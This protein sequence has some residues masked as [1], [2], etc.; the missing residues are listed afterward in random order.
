M[1]SNSMPLLD[2]GREVTNNSQA[3]TAREWLVTNGIGGF[4][5]GTIANLLTRRYQG[6]LVAALQPR[7]YARFY[8]RKSMKRQRMTPTAIHFLPTVGKSR[9]PHWNRWAISISNGF[10]WMGQ[11]RFGP[12]PWPMQ[13]WKNACGWNRAPI[14]PTF[15]TS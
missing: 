3:A 1:T 4:A 12:M 8:W 7:P 11:R 10:T 5:S 15:G 9:R 6:L 13:G 14:Q 2:F